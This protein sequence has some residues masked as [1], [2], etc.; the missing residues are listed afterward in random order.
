ANRQANGGPG[1]FPTATTTG[2]VSASATTTTPGFVIVTDVIG[3]GPVEVTA[4]SAPNMAVFG[5]PAGQATAALDWY[6]DLSSYSVVTD[7][8]FL[9]L[10][11]NNLGQVD[12]P[13]DNIFV[14]LDGGATWAL[15]AYNFDFT[16]AVPPGWNGI[17]VD[18]SGALRAAGLTFTSN[19]VVRV[20]AAG[21]ATSALMV[22]NVWAGIPGDLRVERLTGAPVASGTDDDLGSVPAGV[23]QTV[24]YTLHNDGQSDLTIDPTGLGIVT[25]SNATLLAGP[26]TPIT[27]TPGASRAVNFIMQVSGPGPFRV[28][29][30]VPTSDPRLTNGLFALNI[31][32][33]GVVEPNIAVT[34]G[35]GTPLPNGAVEAIGT[36]PASV[37][38]TRSYF[39][40]NLGG[41]ALTITSAAI[42]ASNNVTAVIG[43]APGATV[44]GGA[45]SPYTVIFTPTAPG[46]FSYEVAIA[47]NDPDTATY[48]V[49]SS[50]TA[51]APEIAVS[52]GATD[53][54]NGG[55][56]DLGT[57]QTGVG[58]Q[59]T[60]TI[61]N[62]GNADLAVSGIAIQGANNVVA[63]ISTATVATVP[64]G[65]SYDVTVDVT[66]VADGAYDFE[67]VISSDDADEGTFLIAV[68]GTAFT[69]APEISVSR[70]GSPV[71]NGATEEAGSTAPGVAQVWTYTIANSGT[72]DL[73]LS[74]P[75]AVANGSNVEVS[76]TQQPSTTIVAGASASLEVTYTVTAVGAYSFDI[77]IGNN[78]ADEGNFTITV[79]GTGDE[80]APE[81]AVEQPVGTNRASGDV[82]SLG[83]VAPGT[84]QALTFTVKNVGAGP[85]TLSGNPLVALSNITNATAEITAQPAATVAAGGSSTFTLSLT[86]SAAGTFGAV[87]TIAND[88]GDEGTF[89]LTVSGTGKT[90]GTTDPV[91]RDSGG[92]GCT[93]AD[94]ETQATPAW[95]G[96]ALGLLLVLRRRRR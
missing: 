28:A 84:A 86:P 49:T 4:S 40:R 22:D 81:I 30:T 15:S 20:Q 64:I 93:A 85:L 39:V 59:L 1:T 52:R 42:Q 65:G 14:S 96:L 68:N 45:N 27:L 12:H 74:G 63:T 13:E 16:T 41:G 31:V 34:R 47:S 55:A 78:D 17:M 66:S 58:Q 6:F 94:T 83:E 2:S 69:P 19:M 67:L 33:T 9:A 92:C 56:D 90:S 37:Q 29:V 89:T 3:A 50:G 51:V 7:D 87:L 71:N 5:F 88:D 95:A 70:G 11:W 57:T 75:V 25:L 60:Y 36:A 18:I 35:D 54:P 62:S 53:F 23:P 24:Q 76:V 61:S 82:I 91:D 79:R 48:V 26:T 43:V 46:S 73:V 10:E 32:G 77:Q 44:A 80:L 21:D 38:A 8:V 72:A